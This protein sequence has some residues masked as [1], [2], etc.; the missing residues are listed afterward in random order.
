MIFR[1]LQARQ[2]DWIYHF[3]RLYAIDLRP[4]KEASDQKD[5]PDWLNFSPS[6]GL[7]KEMEQNEH[8]RELA[9]FRES[10]DE[11]YHEAVEEAL[12]APP[13]ITVEAYEAVYG[14]FPRG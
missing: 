12:N 11:G 5:E 9:K 2:L 6:E 10:L 14:C 1:R 4:L 3:P 7:A 8:D 13:P